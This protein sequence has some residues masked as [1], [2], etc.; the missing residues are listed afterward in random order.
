ML[1]LKELIRLEV[2]K[3]AK[4]DLSPYH[5]TKEKIRNKDN[6]ISINISNK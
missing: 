5:Q 6:K 1:Q 3:V 2:P 4:I